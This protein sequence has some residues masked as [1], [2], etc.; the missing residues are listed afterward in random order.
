MPLWALLVDVE[1][2]SATY[3]ADM[4]AMVSLGALLDATYRIGTLAYPESPS[5][6]F[7]HHVGDSIIIVGEFGADP[8]DQAVAVGVALLHCVLRVRGAAKA[9]LAEG[10][11]ADVAGCF[12]DSI[13]KAMDASPNGRLRLGGGIMTVLPVMGTAWINAYRVQGDPECPSGNL[14]VV[15]KS[16]ADKVP[17]GITVRQAGAFAVIDWL[18]AESPELSQLLSKTNL[19]KREP[20]VEETALREYLASTA[21]PES[22]AT[23]TLRLLGLAKGDI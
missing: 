20:L 2:F 15:P 4:Q 23:N 18:H 6:L 10:D 13:R 19:F 5:R 14:F 17:K 8:L 1:G 11:F 16:L 12:P 21:V 7:A 3:E 9:V 22:W